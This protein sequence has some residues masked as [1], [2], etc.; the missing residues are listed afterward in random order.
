MGRIFQTHPADLERMMRPSKQQRR[1]VRLLLRMLGA[2]RKPSPEPRANTL[3]LGVGTAEHANRRRS[4][5]RRLSLSRPANW[6]R[7]AVPRRSG[8]AE[9]YPWPGRRRPYHLCKYSS[10]LV[11]PCVAVFARL[12]SFASLAAPID[13]HALCGFQ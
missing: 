9:R 3:E 12:A 10:T 8:H 11:S 4:H 7:V 13:I 1:M 5:R 2:S 6:R